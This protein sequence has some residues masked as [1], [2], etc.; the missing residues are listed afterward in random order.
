MK[1]LTFGMLIAVFEEIFGTALFWAMVIAAVLVLAAFVYVLV[2]ERSIE[3][4]RF[5]RAELWGLPI[6]AVAAIA[7]VLW[8]TNSALNDLGGPIDVI[9]MILVG[10]A[11]AVMVTILAYVVQ[12]LRGLRRQ[13]H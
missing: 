2:R 12:G 4:G 6:G 11:G 13:A 10:I 1:E 9:L 5:L 3:S 7:F 8:V